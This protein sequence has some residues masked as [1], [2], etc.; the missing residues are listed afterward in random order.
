LRRS[1]VA[2]AA[3]ARVDRNVVPSTFLVDVFAQFGVAA[4]IIPNIIDTERFRFREREPLRPLLLSTRNFEPLYN[5]ACTLRA[6]RL[7]QDRFPEATLTLVGGGREEPALRV[8]ADELG[9]QHMTFT[10]P[11]DPAPIAA[12]YASHDIYIQ[13][14]NI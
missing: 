9:L 1:G 5:V 12:Q 3:I 8:L 6:F 14:P 4:T 7:V 2:R 13:S 11:V 10:G